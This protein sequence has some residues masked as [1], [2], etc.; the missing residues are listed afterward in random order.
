[1]TNKNLF[2]TYL[3]HSKKTDVENPYV[4]WGLLGCLGCCLG[5]M[6]KRE[7]LSSSFYEKTAE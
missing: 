2:T 5:I 4:Y 6:V 3:L 7:L 1:M